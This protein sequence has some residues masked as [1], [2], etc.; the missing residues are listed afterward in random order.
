MRRADLPIIEGLLVPAVAVEMGFATNPEDKKKLLSLNKQTEIA[1]ALAKS[2]K[3]FYR[4]FEIERKSG[5]KFGELRP[6]NITNN[7]LK[8]TAG[9]V[10]V[11]FGNT[12]VF[13]RIFG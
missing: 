2:I 10:L 3:S 7:Y 8:N 9:S 13:A 6:I 1:K 4:W 5:R 11:E 12:K